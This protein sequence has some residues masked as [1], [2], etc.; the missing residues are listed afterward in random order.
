MR[1][2]GNV[3]FAS[4]SHNC[5]SYCCCCQILLDLFVLGARV[6]ILPHFLEVELLRMYLFLLLFLLGRWLCWSTS[7]SYVL[8]T[9]P[10]FM[11]TQQSRTSRSLYAQSTCTHSL[12]LLLLLES[13]SLTTI[14]CAYVE[15]LCKRPPRL[16]V[17]K[18]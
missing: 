9:A 5:G 14:F 15:L 3:S 18:S 11:S 12:F 6:V 13:A 4:S 16:P 17:F 2:S 1:S 8:D 7:L 10:S